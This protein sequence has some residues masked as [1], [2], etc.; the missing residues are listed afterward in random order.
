VQVSL[1]RRAKSFLP[2]SWWDTLRR[3]KH[4]SSDLEAPKTMAHLRRMR[5]QGFA[6]EVVVDVGAATGDWTVSCRRIFPAARYVMIEPLALY[7]DDLRGL[8]GHRVEHIAVAAGRTR[9]ELPLLLP[10]L[11]EG[12]S[13]LPSNRE[14]DPY[15]KGSI[16][17]PV[18]PVDD[19]DIPFG[20]TLLKLDVQGYELEVLAGA[21]RLIERVEV[22]VAEASMHPFQQRMPLIH[23]LV[24]QVVQLG[25]RLYDVADELRWPSG[26]LAQV[27]VVFVADEHPL[28]DPRWWGAP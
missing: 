16:D 27:D 18:V 3:L 17:V 25:F 7:R 12:S 20:P 2:R 11:P 26:G 6:P 22:I 9:T 1:K 8:V 4:R 23:E 21:S 13:F 10:N 28:L 24:S 19:L 5:Q 14:G 15:F